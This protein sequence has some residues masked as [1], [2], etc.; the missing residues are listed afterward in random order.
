MHSQ[1]FFGKCHF[2]DSQPATAA[3]VSENWFRSAS[4][5]AIPADSASRTVLSYSSGQASVRMTLPTSCRSPA[6]KTSS[7]SLRPFFRAISL[8]TMATPMECSRRPIMALCMIS[9]T[10]TLSRSP[11]TT[12]S[13]RSMTAWLTDEIRPG[14]P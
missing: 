5:M 12:F 8:E 9:K 14:N 2:S 4:K 13:P 1:S 6:T 11:L 10:E 7:G 3:W